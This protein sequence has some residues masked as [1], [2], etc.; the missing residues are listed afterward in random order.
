MDEELPQKRR[1]KTKTETGDDDTTPSQSTDPTVVLRLRPPVPTVADFG[2][3]KEPSFHAPSEEHLHLDP[4]LAMSTNAG[5]N[6][7][8]TDDV[9]YN[10]KGFRYLSCVPNTALTDILYSHGETKPY[11]T[12]MSFADRSP[13]LHLDQGAR[14][15]SCPGGFRSGRA[16][17][18]LRTGNW[19]HE[20]VVVS[21]NDGP[22][23]GHVR[24][25]YSRREASLEA[26]VGFDGYGYGI[27]DVTG[28]KVHVS[29]NKTFMDSFK[30]GDTL[31]F[32]IRLPETSPCDYT[33][34][35][36]DRYPIKF[37]NQLYFELLEYLPSKQM[38]N[39]MNPK[40]PGTFS[41]IATA[42]GAAPVTVPKDHKS[43]E[44]EPAVIPG[45]EIVVF[46][47]GERVGT[48]F[49]DLL[50]FRPPWSKFNPQY[51]SGDADDGLL[52]YYPTVSCFKGGQVELKFERQEFGQLPQEIA[53]GLDSGDIR[54]V[55]DRFDEQVAEDVVYDVMDQIGFELLS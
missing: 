6:L 19:Y 50:D 32:L 41:A 49:E 11:K 34:L 51:H 37:K 4:V 23:S 38:E 48:M 31:G 1:R 40:K 44:W 10:K 39:W 17:A 33:T 9:P 26:P 45:S 35:K 25:G 47:N 13:L 16:T 21:A 3:V 15:A 8:V 52:G 30:T 7:S 29:R 14:V 54:A 55:G 36:R 22:G 43:D 42:G 20:A 5:H 27:R 2:P 24:L 53:D 12:C 46:K 18:C 28:D